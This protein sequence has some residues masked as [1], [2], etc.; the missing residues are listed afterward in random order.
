MNC[1]L[2]SNFILAD[3]I[4]FHVAAQIADNAVLVYGLDLVKIDDGIFGEHHA[5]FCRFD[6]CFFYVGGKA[7]GTVIR[8][9]WSDDHS[10]CEVILDLLTKAK[11]LLEPTV[12]PA[13]Q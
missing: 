6:D 2:T 7:V 12:V 8:G 4:A 10:V 11:I 3:D 9:G 5:I 13:E 1:I